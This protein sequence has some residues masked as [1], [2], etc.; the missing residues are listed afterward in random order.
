MDKQ[1][2]RAKIR[3]LKRQHTTEELC[4][5]SR[6]AAESLLKRIHQ[7]ENCHTVLLYHSLSDEVQTHSL[8]QALAAEGKTVLLP[9]IVGDELELHEY[10]GEDSFSIS[11]SFGIQ[12][13]TGPLFT[14]YSQI[15]LAIIPGVAFTLQGERLGRGKGF[16]DRLLPKLQ[17]PLIGL[18]YPFQIIDF[19]PCEP[20]DIRMTEIVY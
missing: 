14:R 8:I 11:Q 10:I 18:A 6:K 2:I 1:Q 3:Q 4:A 17:C 16:Y 7:E 19:I 5:L 20:H 9:T 12:E 13:S 15:N